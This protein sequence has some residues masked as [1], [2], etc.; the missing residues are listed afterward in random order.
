MSNWDTLGYE[1]VRGYL[2][3]AKRTARTQRHNFLQY[4]RR[5]GLGEG[6]VARVCAQLALRLE[7]LIKNPRLNVYQKT[8]SF[9][10][11]TNAYA[12]AV[13]DAQP[14]TEPESAPAASEAAPTVH[15][16]DTAVD[17]LRSAD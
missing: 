9:A 5:A 1:P 11:I 15:S 6:K 12:K 7:A 2:K 16:P 3:P 10:G 8:A 13:T 4:L 14:T 17:V